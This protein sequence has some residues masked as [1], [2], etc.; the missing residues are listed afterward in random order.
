MAIVHLFATYLKKKPKRK[1]K[2]KRKVVEERDSMEHLRASIAERGNAKPK[3][4]L[5][6][7]PKMLTPLE[8]VKCNYCKKKKKK[9][10]LCYSAILNVKS[11]RSS[12]VKTKIV[13]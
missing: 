8:L 13:F 5:A 3:G 11:H 2:R 9:I 1:R 7:R 6:F 10:Q 4:I 12:M